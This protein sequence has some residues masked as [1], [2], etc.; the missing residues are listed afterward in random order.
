MSRHASSTQA[1]HPWR[2]TLRTIF[3]ALIGLASAWIVIVE[4][5]GL[6][7]GIPWVATSIAV[8]G[9]ITR[10]MAI[11]GVIDWLERFLP[12]LAPG[13]LSEDEVE[14]DVPVS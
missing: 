10:V 4:A 13:G 9:A 6:D 2:A 1:A 3:A 5:I 11:P 8:T 14:G 12:W 7:P